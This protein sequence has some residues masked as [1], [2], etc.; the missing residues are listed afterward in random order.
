[1]KDNKILCRFLSDVVEFVDKIRSVI[2]ETQSTAS[3]SKQF[4]NILRRHLRKLD[5]L[6]DKNVEMVKTA[7]EDMAT[8]RRQLTTE[9]VNSQTITPHECCPYGTFTLKVITNYVNEIFT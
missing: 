5:K 6:K 8:T 3:Q 2:R 7:Q 1:M 4:S 9:K